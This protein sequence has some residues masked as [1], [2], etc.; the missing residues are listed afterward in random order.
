MGFLALFAR[1]KKH[2]SLYTLAL[3][4]L[5]LGLATSCGGKDG[6]AP[7]V[8]E[9][10]VRSLQ[11]GGTN[12]MMYVEFKRLDPGV[13]Y[14]HRTGSNSDSYNGETATGPA[15]KCPTGKYSFRVWY[16]RVVAGETWMFDTP[17]GKTHAELLVNGQVKASLDLDSAHPTF[18][19]DTCSRTVTLQVQ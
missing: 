6:S 17:Q 15:K 18:E 2:Y 11:T 4:V 5:S 14:I 16:P 13:V 8:A 9:L 3:S 7:A 10:A 19:R 12:S 1:M